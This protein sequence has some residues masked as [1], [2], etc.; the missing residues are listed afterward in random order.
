MQKYTYKWLSLTFDIFVELLIRRIIKF[1]FVK[2]SVYVVFIDVEQNNLWARGEM[3]QIMTNT[4][5]S[6]F[7]SHPIQQ[8]YVVTNCLPKCG[9]MWARIFFRWIFQ[10]STCYRAV[11]ERT[12]QC[13]LK[14]W[15]FINTTPPSNWGVGFPNKLYFLLLLSKLLKYYQFLNLIA[16]VVRQHHMKSKFTIS[17]DNFF[18]AK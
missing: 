3:W 18:F 16:F 15:D 11:L 17:S 14:H 7:F 6:I 13:E 1:L 10:V 12:P 2:L 4:N 5:I 8:R 9:E